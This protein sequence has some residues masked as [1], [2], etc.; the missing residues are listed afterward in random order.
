MPVT[1]R[2]DVV[3]IG[4][5]FAG[6]GMAIQLC[7]AGR[8]DF[9]VLER[10]GDLGGTW[11]DNTYPGCA[12]DVPSHL[13]SYSFAPNPGWSRMFAPQP[14]IHGYLRDCARRFGVEPH[15]RLRRTVSAAVYDEAAGEW[16]VHVQG[17]PDAEVVRCRVLVSAIGA[18]Q[19]P[20]MPDL[21][22]LD[23]FTGRAFH[24]ARWPHDED[25]AGRRVAVIG[26]G[27]S[28]VQ[29]VPEIA[30]QAAHLDV[31][32]RTPAWI[33]P[34]PDASISR[35]TRHRYARHPLAQRLVRGIL[36]WVLEGRG[37]GFTLSP[38]L[39]GPMAR[40]ARRH[41]HRQVADPELRARLTPTYRIG[42]KRVLIS[43]AFYPALQRPHV[44]LVVDGIDAFTATGIR[45][46][47]GIE[48]PVDTVVF[49]TGFDL[50]AHLRR[51]RLVGREGRTLEEVWAEEGANAHLGIMVAGF[52]NLFLLL[53]PNTGLG[54]NS[55]LCMIEAQI[56]FVLQAL[57]TL[58]RRG[59]RQ[60][61][62]R[63][64]AQTRS[65][66]RVRRRLTGSVWQS[67]C[68][69]WYLDEHGRNTAMWPGPTPRY[70]LATRRLRRRDYSMRTT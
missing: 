59:A 45:D 62:V 39:T 35:S 2:H 43:S 10:A 11:R 36:Y 40:T 51:L 53:G 49:A 44:E 68:R 16:E 65:V 21:P 67:G 30:R 38:R 42:C 55:V 64:A 20:L 23:T 13:Y 25:L 9:V 60:L 48:R 4:A 54:H 34:R 24:S 47:S 12:C 6:L 28:A 18:L 50:T 19:T 5:G 41:L 33:V 58:D 61:D 3:V 17:G 1:E 66:R 14:E 8:T 26:T 63:P 52:P 7:R 29:I 69:S 31:Y 32:Q 57:R 22:G 70:W 27:A 15:L 56:A 46:R 37:V